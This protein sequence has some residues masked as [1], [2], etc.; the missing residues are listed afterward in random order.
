MKQYDI[1]ELGLALDFEITQP[2]ITDVEKLKMLNNK[3]YTALLHGNLS[4]GYLPSPFSEKHFA[5][6]INEENIVV[7]KYENEIVGYYFIHNSYSGESYESGIKA[8]SENNIL[9]KINIE[10]IGFGVQAAIDKQYQG[11][12]LRPIMLK[13]LIKTV[14]NKYEILF[15]RIKKDNTKAYMG[16]IKDGW[17]IISECDTDVNVI[18]D[19]HNHM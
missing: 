18:F 7:A 1:S 11:L 15:S 19:P 3:W 17:E 6:A 4:H 8:L 5:K 12:G 16:H 13:E 14:F 9:Q 10:K 2:E